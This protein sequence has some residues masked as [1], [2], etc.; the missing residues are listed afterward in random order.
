MDTQLILIVI[1]IALL[2]LSIFL[3]Y[4]SFKFIKHI[5][6]LQQDRRDDINEIAGIFEAM[7]SELREIDIRG[8]FE[9]DDEV[10]SVFKM[11]NETIKKYRNAIND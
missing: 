3:I 9:A 1:S 4:R 10:G 7:L 6:E 5:E 8:S 11:I 2:L